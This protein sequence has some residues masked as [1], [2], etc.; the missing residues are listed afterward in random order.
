MKYEEGVKSRLQEKDSEKQ[1]SKEAKLGRSALEVQIAQ[2]KAEIVKAESENESKQD[3]YE[4]SK[5]AMPFDLRLIDAAEHA[6]KQSKK[7][8]ELRRDDLKNREGLLKELF[9]K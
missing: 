2:L 8:L 6:L 4:S 1:I 3:E 7:T 9:G 5:Y